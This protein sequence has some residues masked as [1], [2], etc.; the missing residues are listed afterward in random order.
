MK[1]VFQVANC[2]NLAG[3]EMVIMNWYRHIDRTKL[4]FDFSVNQSYSTPLVTEIKNMG[5]HIFIISPATGINNRF[6]RIICLYK[7]LKN[8]GPYDVFHTHSHFNAGFDCLAAFLAGV[9][10]RFTISHMADGSEKLT[11]RHLLLRPFYRLLIALFS[12][13]RLAV[14]QDAGHTLYGKHLS[15]RMIH[16]G[17]DLTKFAYN[18]S[19]RVKKRRELNLDNKLIIGHVGRFM[20]QKNHMFLIDIFCEIYK[21][22]PTA[23]L[24]LLG[25]GELEEKIRE[26]VKRLGIAHAVTF[27]GSQR[28]VADFYQAFDA[29]LFPSLYE[30]LGIVAIEAQASGL[31]CFMSDV[32]PKEA[33]VCNAVALSL[34]QFPSVWANTVLNTCANFV[35]KDESGM[36]R[37]AGFDASTVGRCI[38]TEY[39]S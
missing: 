39:I 8:Q 27:M 22:N 20:E 13:N 11:Y 30:G 1:R 37:Q 10:K 34:N 5:G 24:I 35:R 12:T 23:H 7:L 6:K 18:P 33:F 9:P 32:I 31:P 14:S 17:I 21:Q 16:N 29:F 2:L 3:T 25:T 26:K 38:A 28:N 4:Q 15:F 36:L 19:V